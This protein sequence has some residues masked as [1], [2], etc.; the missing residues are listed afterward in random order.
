MLSLAYDIEVLDMSQYFSGKAKWWKVILLMAL[1]GFVAGVV[2]SLKEVLA[3]D[4]SFV[5][6][7]TIALTLMGGIAAAGEELGM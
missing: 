1:I 7:T 2:L 5:F 3:G 6:L 4:W